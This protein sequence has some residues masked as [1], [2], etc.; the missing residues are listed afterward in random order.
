MTGVTPDSQTTFGSAV[1]G[2]L[3]DGQVTG[4]GAPDGAWVRMNVFRCGPAYGVLIV[5]GV[6]ASGVGGFVV[7]AGRV[8]AKKSP[9]SGL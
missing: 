2:V 7:F 4:V 5:Y 9:S 1:V 6:S 3:Q 8:R